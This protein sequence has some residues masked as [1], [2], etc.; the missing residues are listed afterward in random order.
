VFEIGL[1][2]KMYGNNYLTFRSVDY[3]IAAEGFM[4]DYVYL[5]PGSSYPLPVSFNFNDYIEV[6]KELWALFPETDGKRTNFTQIGLSAMIFVEV[7]DQG[8]ELEIDE[9]YMLMPCADLYLRPIRMR[10]C[11][12]LTLGEYRMGHLTA[13]K[14]IGKMSAAIPLIHAIGGSILG[15]EVINE[16]EARYSEDTGEN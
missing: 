13:V 12:R 4:S 11:R 10:A 5:A 9:T 7:A 15:E 3:T 1:I 8:N 16:A 14:L 2:E 6:E